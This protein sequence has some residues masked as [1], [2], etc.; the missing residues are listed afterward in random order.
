MSKYW[1]I[2]LFYH[3]FS[4]FGLLTEYF[5]TREK[6]KVALMTFKVSGT[7]TQKQITFFKLTYYKQIF[8]K[9]RLNYL[10]ILGNNQKFLVNII[11]YRI[12]LQMHYLNLAQF[13][14][15]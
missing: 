9:E 3:S 7:E 11:F 5:E 6:S 15:Y 1:Q 10:K 14:Y 8:L 12:Y 4:K 2:V 13:V